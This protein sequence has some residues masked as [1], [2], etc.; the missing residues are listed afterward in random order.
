MKRNYY[1][2]YL[3]AAAICGVILWHCFSPV[4]YQF[5]PLKEWAFANVF[6]GFAIRWSVAVF[7]MVSG[8]LLLG[9]SEPAAIFYKKRLLR[10]CIPLVT[11]TLI[12][13]IARLYYFK[14]YN[15]KGLPEPS[16]FR[17]VIIDQF[18]DL[19]FND[20]SYHLYFISIILGL[21]LLTPFLSKMVKALSQK[22]LG[23][24]VAIGAGVYSVKLF[25]PRLIIADHFEIGSYLVYFL[26]GHYLYQYPPGK[27]L[28]RWIFGAAIGAA[29][30]M[31]WLN[32]TVEYLHKGH[33]DNYYRTDGFFI[34]VLSI[35]VFTLFQHMSGSSPDGSRGV[36]KRLLSFISSCSYGIYIAHPL[37]I[38]FLIYGHFRFFTFSTSLSFITV[39]GYKVSLIMNNAWGAIVQSMIMMV[40]L[41]IFFYM[42][43]RL[44][45][46]RYFT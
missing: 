46:S 28:R 38:S 33:G 11:W 41:L 2:D 29:I 15:Y 5:G 7:V 34:Y 37:L 12:Y 14:V 9:R 20:L 27:A 32:Y 30:L 26:L 43:K 16:F 39:W 35:A 10:I 13:G 1:I 21:Y 6:F 40:I 45:L 42:V 23:T 17:Y 8:A 24:L 31:T 4:Y 22:E 18:R 36:W 3:R 44:K 25:M 19:L